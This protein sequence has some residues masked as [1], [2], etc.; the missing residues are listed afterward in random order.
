RDPLSRDSAATGGDAGGGKA[1]GDQRCGRRFGIGHP[2]GRRRKHSAATATAAV[3]RNRR[4]PNVVQQ[5]RRATGI[6]VDRRDA[7]RQ[8]IALAQDQVVVEGEI[9]GRNVLVL[10]ASREV[11]VKQIR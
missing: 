4:Q 3:E 6:A 1:Q 7:E 8:L 9:I 2:T 11:G 10:A 5:Q